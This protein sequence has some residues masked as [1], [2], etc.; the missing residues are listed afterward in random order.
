M[1]DLI[2]CRK[3]AGRFGLLASGSPNLYPPTASEH[4]L[5]EYASPIVV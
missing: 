4:P 1:P 2:C 5:L 3:S